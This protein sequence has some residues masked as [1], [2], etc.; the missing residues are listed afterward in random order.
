MS[1]TRK[2]GSDVL[3]LA[4]EKIDDLI[5]GLLN[6]INFTSF[7]FILLLFYHKLKNKTLNLFL[8]FDITG[9][10]SDELEVA[11]S[12]RSQVVSNDSNHDLGLSD[13]DIVKV[14]RSKSRVNSW[15]GKSSF[16][17]FKIN[18]NVSKRAKNKNNDYALIALI[19]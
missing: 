4:L 5:A 1:E 17:K 18:G 8:S 7:L 15:L 6:L 10:N 3:A 2:D 9:Q 12:N 19:L 16:E 14:I 13:S 11:S